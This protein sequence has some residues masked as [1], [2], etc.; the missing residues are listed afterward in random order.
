M[1]VTLEVQS[2]TM[3][4]L[5][6]CELHSTTCIRFAAFIQWLLGILDMDVFQVHDP[7]FD[8]SLSHPD[9]CFGTTLQLV[10]QLVMYIA[11]LCVSVQR[12]VCCSLCVAW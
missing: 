6:L 12:I 2:W 7:F 4:T 5:A 11:L 8:R 9:G 3:S 10:M 1:V